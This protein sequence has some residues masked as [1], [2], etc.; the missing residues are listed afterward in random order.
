MRICAASAAQSKRALQKTHLPAGQGPPQSV[1]E[2]PHRGLA[3]SVQ[4]SLAIESLTD[5]GPKSRRMPRASR[6][7]S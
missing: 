4:G 6:C 2:G 7:D 3:S 1:A 5:M